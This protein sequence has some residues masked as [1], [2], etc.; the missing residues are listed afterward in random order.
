M[1]LE[2]AVGVEC[3]EISIGYAA[4]VGA[5]LFARKRLNMRINSH[6]QSGLIDQPKQRGRRR[7][8]NL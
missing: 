5:N 7:G 3:Y 2:T 6:L 4:D 1:N 8:A